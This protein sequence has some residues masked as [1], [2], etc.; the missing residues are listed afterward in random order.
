MREREE[1]QSL[2]VDGDMGGVEGGSG[3]GG[4]VEGGGGGGGG[5]KGGSGGSNEDGHE[6]V[7]GGGT[8][9]IIHYT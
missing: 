3:G 8:Q 6:S 1:C 2:H 4:G 9:P 5:S 7:S